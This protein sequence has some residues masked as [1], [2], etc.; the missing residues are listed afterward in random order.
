MRLVE[1]GKHKSHSRPYQGFRGFGRNIF[2][3]LILKHDR[4]YANVESEERMVPENEMQY[5]YQGWPMIY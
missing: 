4:V 1:T 3:L 5:S 2:E